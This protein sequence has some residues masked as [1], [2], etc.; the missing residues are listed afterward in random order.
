MS[1]AF[2]QVIKLVKLENKLKLLK[3]I[4]SKTP[5]NSDL[6]INNQLIEIRGSKQYSLWEDEKFM[7]LYK[8]VLQNIENMSP[9]SLVKILSAISL[10][11]SQT[12]EL[13]VLYD[14]V[15]EWVLLKKHPFIY[16]VVVSERSERSPI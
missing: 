6:S 7:D 1:L 11:K 5:G 3:H 10:K 14:R 13:K 15:I 16:W 12:E 8:T 4:K 9:D 2:F